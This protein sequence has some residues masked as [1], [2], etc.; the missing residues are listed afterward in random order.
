MTDKL[1]RVG[2]ETHRK[3]TELG[4]KGET[5]DEIIVGLLES[6]NFSH[7]ILSLCSEIKTILDLN[8]RNAPP[9]SPFRTPAF[10]AMAHDIYERVSKIE[11]LA[12]M[13]GR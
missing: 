11:K 2:E 12:K 1:I 13:K 9:R 7:E 10:L 6:I 3:L 8:R 5:Y 4:K